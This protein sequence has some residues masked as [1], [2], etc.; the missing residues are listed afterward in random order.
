M[1]QA[2]YFPMIFTEVSDVIT[3]KKL[4]NIGYRA[5]AKKFLLP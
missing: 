3:S 1:P 5:N 4:Y 2:A